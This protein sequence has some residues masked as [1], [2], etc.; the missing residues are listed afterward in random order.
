[1][2]K[3]RVCKVGRCPFIHDLNVCIPCPF[4]GKGC[5]FVGQG[6]CKYDH[7]VDRVGG[8]VEDLKNYL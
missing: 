1:M 2:L 8:V 3:G 4:E 6:I 7:Q 5:K